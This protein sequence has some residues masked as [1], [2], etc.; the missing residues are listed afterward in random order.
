[1]LQPTGAA[2]SLAQPDPTLHQPRAQRGMN[3]AGHDGVFVASPPIKRARSD[4]LYAAGLDSLP[5][6]P[7]MTDYGGF[8]VGL[9]AGIG[10]APMS[11]GRSEH[12]GLQ[13]AALERKHPA[14]MLRALHAVAHLEAIRE[15]LCVYAC[16][17]AEFVGCTQQHSTP[18]SASVPLAPLC[19][20]KPPAPLCMQACLAPEGNFSAAGDAL[21]PCFTSPFRNHEHQWL[22]DCF[23]YS[24]L[25]S[26]PAG[27]ANGLARAHTLPEGGHAFSAAPAALP[28]WPV[29]SSSPNRS[30]RSA[31]TWDHP[32]AHTAGSSPG[33]TGPGAAGLAPAG[34]LHSTLASRVSVTED[35]LDPALVLAEEMLGLPTASRERR[36]GVGVV[37]QPP[38]TTSC[39]SRMLLACCQGLLRVCLQPR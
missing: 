11:A 34:S 16:T 6:A 3:H 32:G 24:Q 23:A 30:A 29:D 5:G 20:T 22:D 19:L 13:G 1:M 27:P 4:P 8:Q 31:Q 2:P 21:M 12:L 7:R 15:Q 37:I 9:A 33:A 28:G 14:R 26:L 39:G 17:N 18:T 10:L 25:P 35:L 38:S 36:V